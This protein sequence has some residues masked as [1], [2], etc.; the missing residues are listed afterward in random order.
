M[1]CVVLHVRR[2]ANGLRQ[3][4]REHELA[5]CRNDIGKRTNISAKIYRVRIVEYLSNN[6][7]L[8][9]HTCVDSVI[10]FTSPDF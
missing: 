10:T 8:Q 7:S 9:E 3:V 4:K 5:Y 2:S 1:G 6:L